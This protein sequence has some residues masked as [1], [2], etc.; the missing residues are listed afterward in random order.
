MIVGVPSPEM[1]YERP[2]DAWRWRR[3]PGEPGLGKP[4]AQEQLHFLVSEVWQ[5][6]YSAHQFAGI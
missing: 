1:D 6:Q 3:R 2:E 5:P 4:E